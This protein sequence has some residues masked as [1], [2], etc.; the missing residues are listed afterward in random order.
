MTAITVRAENTHKAMEELLRRLGP[1]ALILSTRHVDGGVELVALPPGGDSVP[2]AA[3]TA[4]DAPAPDGTTFERAFHRESVR[5]ASTDPLAALARR[6]LLPEGLAD[7]P[8]TR[9]IVA[10]PPGAGKSLLAA[11]IAAQLMLADPA[12]RPCLIAPV[13]A[14]SLVEDRL[15]G[16]A[17]LMGLSP[18]RPPVAAAMHLPEPSPHRPQIIDLSD[19]PDDAPMLTARLIETQGAELV[20][21][22]PAGLHPARTATLCRDW[23]AFA[24]TVTLTG[25][26]LW[27]PER[28]ELDAIA[29][30]GLKLTRVAAGTGLIRSLARPAIP[31]LHRWANGW[32]PA[33]AE[34][35]E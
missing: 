34:A 31:D 10:G 15:R 12:I 20:L 14:T 16:W 17:R 27:W 1:D 29:G 33:F 4:T 25:L 5:A 9:I 8:V 26:D 35:A 22:L 6:L 24:P 28:A 32:T 11:R 21:C 13:P 19:C 23:Q 30:A 3:V 18:D 7:D 2:P